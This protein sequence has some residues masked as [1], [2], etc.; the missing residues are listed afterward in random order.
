MRSAPGPAEGAGQ[1]VVWRRRAFLI[2]SGLGHGAPL[3]LRQV[4]GR[5]VI[6]AAGP[7]TAPPEADAS[8]LVRPSHPGGL[9]PAVRTADC[10]PV[11]I[12]DSRGQACAA[13]HAGWRGIAAGIAEASLD[14]LRSAGCNPRDAVVALGPAIGGCCYEVGPDVVDAFRGA[15]PDTTWL[16]DGTGGKTR[17]DLHAALK[18]QLMRAGV[19]R[20]AIHGAPWCTRCRNDLFFSVRVEGQ[21][22]GR[23]M[24]VIGP[25]VAP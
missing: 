2:A 23:L 17:V 1:A 24:A 21:A 12:A 6:D 7:T 5:A 8:V 18:S 4:H 3:I 10:V 13:V 16:V 20:A 19:S 9:F 11:L 15:C 22:T 25:G 14:T